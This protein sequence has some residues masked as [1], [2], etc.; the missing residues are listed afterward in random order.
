MLQQLL[1]QRR[2]LQNI[3]KIIPVIKDIIQAVMKE[4]QRAD[5]VV[6]EICITHT[7]NK[8]FQGIYTLGDRR[9]EGQ[10]PQ[11]TNT[12]QKKKNKKRLDPK[13]LENPPPQTSV[14]L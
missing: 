14:P 13:D 12:S 2:L 7:A 8:D 5:H 3:A 9:R 11:T 4:S 1:L 10:L 6:I